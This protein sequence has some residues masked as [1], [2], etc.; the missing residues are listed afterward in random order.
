MPE[1]ADP[2]IEAPVKPAPLIG[3][4]PEPRIIGDPERYFMPWRLCPGQKCD[5]GDAGRPR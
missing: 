2:E 4:K 1:V 5:G 3:P